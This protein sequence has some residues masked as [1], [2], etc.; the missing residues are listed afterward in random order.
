MKLK[1]RPDDFRVDEL[2]TV[3][4]Q[5]PGR[6][7]FYRL[8]KR[9]LGTIEAVEA[10]CRRWNLSARQVSFAGLK[11]RH[12]VTTQYLTIADGPARTARAPNF[13]LEP[14]GRLAHPYGPQHFRGNRF[15]ILIR[16]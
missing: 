13:E 6:Y 16:D 10:I 4:P 14:V 3:S 12:A 15:G 2:P 11:D 5:G 1:C 7:R 8:T 9:N